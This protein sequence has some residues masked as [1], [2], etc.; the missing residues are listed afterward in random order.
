MARRNRCWAGVSFG[1]GGGSTGG[2]VAIDGDGVRFLGNIN[3]SCR[4]HGTFGS[5]S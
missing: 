2:G 3:V 5:I 1:F 4:T